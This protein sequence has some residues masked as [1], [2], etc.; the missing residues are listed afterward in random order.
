[1]DKARFLKDVVSGLKSDPKRLYSKY[2]YDSRGD[3]LFER[4]MRTKD[5]YPTRCELEIFKTQRTSIADSV[6][7]NKKKLDII[8]LGPGDSSKTIYLIEELKKR[9]ALENY[10][11]IDISENI[12]TTLRPMFTRKFPDVSF[13]GLAGEYFD[14]LPEVLEISVNTRLVFFVGATIG[15]FL[16]E[17]M[18]HFCQQLKNNL[19]KGDMALIGFDLK[20]DPRKILAAYND[21]EG[22]TAKFNLN[23]LSRINRELGADF[24]ENRFAHF[25]TYDPL[26]GACKSFLVSK[27]DQ[28]VHIGKNVISFWKGEPVHT[29]ISQKYQLQEI[30]AAAKASG[31]KQ[32]A[33][34][35]DSKKY[36][37]DV[38]WQVQ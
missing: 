35:Q 38:L 18:L 17:Q 32:I 9:N 14:K 3:W 7:R 6:L 28:Q 29:E 23:L 8:A 34:Y 13:K 25:P 11:P 36:F 30:E 21:S 16:P 26:T 27:I 15:N 24:R 33:A 1:M 2:F 12:I 4:I 37:V 10:F 20:K 19:K 5:Y 22:W 31:F